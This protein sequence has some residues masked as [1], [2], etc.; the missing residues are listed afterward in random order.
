MFIH[1]ILFSGLVIFCFMVLPNLILSGVVVK[2]VVHD[3][4]PGCYYNGKCM[5]SNQTIM[6][7]RTYDCILLECRGNYADIKKMFCL[8]PNG[9]CMAHEDKWR[10]RIKNTCVTFY[11]EI[12]NDKAQLSVVFDLV[13]FPDHVV[14]SMMYFMGPHIALC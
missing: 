14:G 9:N 1:P 13:C 11:C 2:S 6:L 10:G 7:R 8:D 4:C 5:C 12:I 3:N